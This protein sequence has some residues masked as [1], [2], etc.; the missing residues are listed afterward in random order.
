MPAV[1]VKRKGKNE[2]IKTGNIL[3]KIIP[4]VY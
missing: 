1:V 2:Q 3:L 4:E